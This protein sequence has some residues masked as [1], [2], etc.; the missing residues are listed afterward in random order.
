MIINLMALIGLILNFF[1]TVLIF[2]PIIYKSPNTFL[3][4]NKNKQVD[5]FFKEREFN[6]YGFILIMIGFF[7]QAFS[8]FCNILLNIKKN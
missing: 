3:F 8:V 4:N 7:A 5:E 6:V 2:K 1:G